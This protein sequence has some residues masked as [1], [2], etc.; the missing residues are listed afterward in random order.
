V[1][2]C[3]QACS[4]MAGMAKGRTEVLISGVYSRRSVWRG[5]DVNFRSK[6]VTEKLEEVVAAYVMTSGKPFQMTCML[7]YKSTIKAQICSHVMLSQQC[8]FI[9]ATCLGSS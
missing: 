6:D 7:Y 9:S 1:D 4:R 8:L 2:N 5:G 3:R